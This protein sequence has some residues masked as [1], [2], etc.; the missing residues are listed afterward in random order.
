MSI[1]KV[2]NAINRKE[3]RDSIIDF[4]NQ[5][6]ANNEAFIGDTEICPLT[7]KFADGIYVR[8][9]FIPAGMYIVGK[10]H[11]HKHPNFLLSGT[12]DV[13][14]ESGGEERLTGP[15]AIISEAGTKR[16]LRTITDVRWVTVH[17]N[18]SNTRDIKKLED[19]I[20]ANSFD[21]FDKFVVK[22]NSY[23]SKIK[24]RLKTIFR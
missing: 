24:R 16:A 11:K 13:I 23:L 20:I 7:H 12:V 5:I 4:E 17:L 10:I 21:E 6:R 18:E 19:E 2:N 3:I 15:M 14:T 22:K 1:V 8:E 9:I